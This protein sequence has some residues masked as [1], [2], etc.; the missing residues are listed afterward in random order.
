ML[1]G[2]LAKLKEETVILDLSIIVNLG[3]FDTFCVVPLLEWAP[4]GPTICPL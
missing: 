2:A 3:L 1:C 4:L